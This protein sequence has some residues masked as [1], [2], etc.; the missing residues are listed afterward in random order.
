MVEPLR[1][2]IDINHWRNWN[3][4]RL[5]Y[6]RRLF[7]EGGQDGEPPPIE[8]G[9]NAARGDRRLKLDGAIASKPSD[10]WAAANDLREIETGLWNI[11]VA[12]KTAAEELDSYWTGPAGGAFADAFT[13]ISTHV[14]DTYNALAPWPPTAGRSYSGMADEVGNELDRAQKKQ[15]ELENNYANN[16]NQKVGEYWKQLDEIYDTYWR[17]NDWQHQDED[18]DW[19]KVRWPY[20]WTPWKDQ[21]TTDFWWRKYEKYLQEDYKQK[22]LETNLANFASDSLTSQNTLQ[23]LYTT[24]YWE[25][26]DIPVSPYFQ[27]PPP[28]TPPKN[29]QKNEPLEIKF[30]PPPDPPKSPPPPDL[31]GG[32]PPGGAPDLGAPGGAPDLGTPGGAPDLGTPSGAPDLSAPGGAPG[33]LPGPGGTDVPS[34]D[35]SLP[36]GRD[37][38][39]FG[40][41]GSAAPGSPF[42]PPGG[43]DGPDATSPSPVPGLPVTALP[44]G[45]GGRGTAGQVVTGRN[46]TGM[47]VTGNGIPDLDLDGKPMAGGD[48]PPGAKVVTGP[49]GTR[50]IDLDKD[51]IPDVD[52]AGRALPGGNAPV[53]ST[54]VNGPDGVGYDLTG[55]GRPDVGLDGELLPDSPLNIGGDISDGG[56]ETKPFVRP[57]ETSVTPGDQL[58][59][60]GGPGGEFAQPVTGGQPAA[61]QSAAP[62]ASGL[63]SPMAPM[64]PPM[65]PP[66]GGQNNERERQTWLLED[67][68]VWAEDRLE[69]TS[70]LGRPDDSDDEPADDAWEAP[71]RKKTAKGRQSTP[72][73]LQTSWSRGGR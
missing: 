2:N 5:E 31:P 50:G 3:N 42:D 39:E 8:D 53:G 22:F 12:L 65:M 13:D 62:A 9:D 33:S 10:A 25:M 6:W 43:P 1:D 20:Q 30:P 4:T 56:P 34:L 67:D 27:S 73:T 32:G 45:F 23:D 18:G 52:M 49:D 68:E 51:G 38:P 7:Y 19:Y 48:L 57:P 72:P 41:P 66:Q 64:M 61:A 63:N 44:P 69:G 16:H 36:G 58:R 54:L 40:G 11:S 29:D 26:R 60:P 17:Y 24:L 35:S 28:P 70:V 21:A 15:L 46:G 59:A 55:D 14:R 37:A 71:A 47:D